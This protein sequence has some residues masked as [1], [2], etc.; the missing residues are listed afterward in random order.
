MGRVL[1]RLEAWWMAHD[2]PETG[3]E[4]RLAEL[5]ARNDEA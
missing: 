3:L 5:I 1:A 4:E 2:F